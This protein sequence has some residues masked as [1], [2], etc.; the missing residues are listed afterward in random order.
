MFF[1]EKNTI[2]MFHVQIMYLQYKLHSYIKGTKLSL[3]WYHKVQKHLKSAYL[4]EH[5]TFFGNRLIL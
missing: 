4:K 2:Q 1:T 5:S 3:V